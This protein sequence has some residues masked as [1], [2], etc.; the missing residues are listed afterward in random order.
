MDYS[1]IKVYHIL[2]RQ[3]QQAYNK[4]TIQYKEVHH[5]VYDKTGVRKESKR[6]EKP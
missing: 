2:T 4:S 3:A 1:R 5:Y 6:I